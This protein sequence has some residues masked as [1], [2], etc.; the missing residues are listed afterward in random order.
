MENEKEKL[1][2]LNSAI[3]DLDNVK[4]EAKKNISSNAGN[5]K[6]IVKDSYDIINVDSK[7]FSFVYNRSVFFE[8]DVMFSIDVSYKV[9]IKFDIK[10]TKE[11]EGKLDELKDLVNIKI[12]KAINMVRV[13][14]RASALISSIT[15]QNN[16][17]AIIT[18]PSFVKDNN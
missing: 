13:S 2:Y 15:M 1:I 7:G 17:N 9:Q 18:Q 6:V 12:E 8:P 5:F 14:A 3:I 11:Y 16:G 10:T 4:Y